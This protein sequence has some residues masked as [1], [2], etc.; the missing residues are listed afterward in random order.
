MENKERG[1]FWKACRKNAGLTAT[2][3]AQR[4]GL[5]SANTVQKFER[6]GVASKKTLAGLHEVLPETRSTEALV[7]PISTLSFGD[8]L[9]TVRTNAGLSQTAAAAQVGFAATASWSRLER[10]EVSA[11]RATSFNRIL[12]VFPELHTLQFDHP[13]LTGGAPLLAVARVKNLAPKQET[14]RVKKL[15]DAAKMAGVVGAPSK[16]ATFTRS[17]ARALIQLVR[18]EGIEQVRA[19]LVAACKSGLSLTDTLNELDA[20]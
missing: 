12:K 3:L 13:K 18:V 7:T 14:V 16:E 20:L 8:A 6:L 2:E 4:L 17:F 9:H 19:F 11:L 5:A 1:A 15:S 10:G